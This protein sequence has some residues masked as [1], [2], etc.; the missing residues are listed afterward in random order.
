MA[1]TTQL[2]DRIK[3]RLARRAFS[4]LD[5]LIYDE[6]E[7][8]QVEILEKDAFLPNFLKS[9]GDVTLNPGVNEISLGGGTL[10]RFLRP[11]SKDDQASLTYLQDGKYIKVPRYDSLEQIQ[12]LFPGTGPAPQGYFWNGSSYPGAVYLVFPVPSAIVNFRAHFYRGEGILSSVPDATNQWTLQ[13][14]DL[15]MHTA[16]VEIATYLRDKD[17]LNYFAQ[18]RQEAYQRLVNR[19]T[20]QDMADL[21]LSMGD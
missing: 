11:L 17:A 16:G 9:Y 7:H 18:K 3:V 4:N 15:L 12:Q 19:T 6:M 2:K 20:S 21:D 10:A 8:A 5:A 1:T 13:G 14:A